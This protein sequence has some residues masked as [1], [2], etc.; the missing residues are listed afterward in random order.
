MGLIEDAKAKFERAVACA[1]DSLAS[2]SLYAK[3]VA[4]FLIARRDLQD[5]KVGAALDQLLDAIASCTALASGSTSVSKLVGDM[6]SFLAAFPTDMF[7]ENFEPTA[8]N[9]CLA[10]HLNIISRGAHFYFSSLEMLKNAQND[11]ELSDSESMASLV[12]DG[13]VNLLL[14]AQLSS[15]WKERGDHELTSDV[16]IANSFQQA[17]DRFVKALQTDPMYAPAWCGLGCAMKCEK[18]KAQHAFSTSIDI[19]S[20]APDPY[21]N[22]GFLYFENEEFGKSAELCDVLTQVADTYMTWINRACQIEKDLLDREERGI[23]FVGE[24]ADAYRASLQ[25]QRDPFAVLGLAASLRLAAAAGTDEGGEWENRVLLDEYE[26]LTSIS[27]ASVFKVLPR[28]KD[29]RS[30]KCAF[31]ACPRSTKRAILERPDRGDMWLN[32]S[33]QLLLEADGEVDECALQP[34]RI[35]IRRA[36]SLLLGKITGTTGRRK[37]EDISAWDVSES[38]ALESWLDGGSDINSNKFSQLALLICPQN[39][40]AR[41]TLSTKWY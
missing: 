36:A 1:S 21:A 9:E 11:T 5:G 38:L 14:R 39:L 40:V 12:C 17:R 28:D 27:P 31:P 34:A 29:V 33:R 18:L 22:L 3:G 2:A 16:N 26:S 10:K 15:C 4:A 37:T 20:S 23:D 35:A 32:L 19:D 25:V 24:M 30:D 7:G 13:A 41:K 8:S 6:H